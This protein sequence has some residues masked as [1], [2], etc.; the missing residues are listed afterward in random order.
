MIGWIDHI[1]E[2]DSDVHDEFQRNSRKRTMALNNTPRQIGRGISETLSIPTDDLV[3]DEFNADG[4]RN[5]NG[6]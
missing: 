5:G 4:D 6:E 3:V 1:L 2:D